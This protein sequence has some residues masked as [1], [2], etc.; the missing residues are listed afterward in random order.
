MIKAFLLCKNAVFSTYNI[1][2]DYV[3]GRPWAMAE[4]RAR[5]GRRQVAS[6]LALAKTELTP[7]A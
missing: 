6:V 5:I 4:S 7:L 2:T 1:N 3:I